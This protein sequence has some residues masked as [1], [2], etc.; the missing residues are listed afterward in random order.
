[1]WVSCVCVCKLCVCKL[2]VSKL[3]VVKL[4]VGKLCVGKCCVGKWCVCVEHLNRCKTSIVFL[5]C[6]GVVGTLG[7]TTQRRHSKFAV[8]CNL[9]ADCTY[10]HFWNSNRLS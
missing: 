6:R 8:I 4:F 5:V 1:M 7:V 2:C 9:D 10:L 3:C